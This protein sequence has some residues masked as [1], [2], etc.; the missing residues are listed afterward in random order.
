MNEIIT[1]M[2]KEQVDSSS[3]G[4]H[5]SKE[6]GKIRNRYIQVPHQ[7]PRHHMG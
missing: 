5:K 2:I 4:M 6:E 1:N 7:G 3:N